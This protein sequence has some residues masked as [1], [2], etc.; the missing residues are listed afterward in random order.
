MERYITGDK[1]DNLEEHNI[2]NPIG[3]RKDPK[4]KIWPFKVHHANQ[5]YDPVN[6][7]LIPPLT[8]GD[9]GYWTKFDWKYAIAKGATKQSALQWKIWIHK[10]K[11]V[12][13]Y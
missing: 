5:P 6:N 10:N 4:A 9:G 7:I 1:L 3:S 8:S 12:L 11:N 2:N 13:A